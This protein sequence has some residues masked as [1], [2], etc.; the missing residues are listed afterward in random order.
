MTYLK[1]ILAITAVALC[2]AAVAS[3]Q[4][5]TITGQ[6]TDSTGAAV[7]GATITITQTKTGE[8]RTTDSSGA[9]LYT[10]P[11]LAVGTYDLKANATGFQAYTKTGIVVNEASTFRADVTLTVGAASQTVTVQANALQV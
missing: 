5:G 3:A 8:T 1:R 10:M 11:G 4:E 6:V 9:G 2:M 7:P